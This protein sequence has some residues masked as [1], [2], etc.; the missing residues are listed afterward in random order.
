[1]QQIKEIMAV[2]D[3]YR[4]DIKRSPMQDIAIWQTLDMY[5]SDLEAY[6]LVATST[7]DEAFE[8][9]LADNWTFKY[10][11]YGLDYEV[12]DELVLD[13]LRN[14]QLV[15]DREETNGNN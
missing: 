8:R 12:I 13:Y 15:T 7:K 6:E 11:F 10:D 14:N 5:Y 4:R 1:M 9:M 2:M 3:S